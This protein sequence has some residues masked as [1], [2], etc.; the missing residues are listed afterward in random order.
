M[1]NASFFGLLNMF[2]VTES[3]IVLIQ[4]LLSTIIIVIEMLQSATW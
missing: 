4:C 2:D 3:F 1:L